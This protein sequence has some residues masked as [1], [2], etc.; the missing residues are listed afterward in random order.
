VS[1]PALDRAWEGRPNH[2]EADKTDMG[3]PASFTSSTA[4]VGGELTSNPIVRKLT[5]SGS[6][7]VGKLLMSSAPARSKSSR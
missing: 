3:I 6:T 4:Q 7:E 2:E 1:G 5:C